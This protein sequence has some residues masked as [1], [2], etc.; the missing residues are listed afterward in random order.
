MMLAGQGWMCVTYTREKLKIPY[1]HGG[2]K[3]WLLHPNA[4][5]F[6]PLYFKALLLADVHKQ[7]VRHN[8]KCIQK[9]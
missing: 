5:K 3:E 2:A 4:A 6:N 8:G 7:P 9:G 1:T